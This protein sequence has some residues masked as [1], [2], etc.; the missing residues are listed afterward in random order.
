MNLVSSTCVAL[1]L[2]SGVELSAVDTEPVQ[3]RGLQMDADAELVAS[4]DDP[5]PSLP[6]TNVCKRA[7]NAYVVNGR[8]YVPLGAVEAYDESGLA[9]WFGDEVSGRQTVCGESVN[10]DA[11]T[12]MHTILP[13]P[14]KVRVTNLESGISVILRVND[15]GPFSSNRI[16]SVSEEAARRLGFV[17]QKTAQVRVERLNFG[18]P[19]SVQPD[20]PQP[21]VMYLETDKVFGAYNA[22]TAAATL[23]E[24]LGVST[25]I[26]ELI[27]DESYRIRIGPFD[28]MEAAEKARAVLI[29]RRQQELNLVVE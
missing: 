27:R 2:F 16:I 20:K 7:N 6:Q 22:A 10:K 17:A 23:K 1:A 9:S 24:L 8:R 4:Q 12:A 15:R 28:S 11:M 18:K 26:V 14:S 25:E 19:V 13:L 3:L 5:T 21:R 29:I